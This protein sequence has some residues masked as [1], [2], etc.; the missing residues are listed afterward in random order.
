MHLPPKNRRTAEE[1]RTFLNDA[2]KRFQI[3][4]DSEASIREQAKI[5][6]AYILGDQWAPRAKQIRDDD[7]RPCLTINRLPQFIHQVTNEQRQL[8][9]SLQVSP[10][11][12][13]ESLDT[14]TMRTYADIWQGLM[15]HIEVNSDAETAY[16][17]A[18]ESMVGISFGWF[19]VI[20]EYAG[21]DTFDQEISIKR[22]LD[23]FSVYVDP[24]AIEPDR[25]DMKWAFLTSSMSREQFKREYPNTEMVTLDFFSSFSGGLSQEWLTDQDVQIAEYY[26]V[27]YD[28]KTLQE[29]TAPA[30]LAEQL[31]AIFGEDK[32][33]KVDPPTDGTTA[34]GT[35]TFNAYSDD[36]ET[37]PKG[38]TVENER[39]VKVPMVKWYK[40]TGTDIL[41]ETDWAG[42]WI[43]LIPAIGHEAVKDGKK[44]IIS[45]TRFIRDSQTL[46]NYFRSQQAEVIALTPKAPFIGPT[47]SFKTHRLRWQ[48]ANNVNYSYL[49]FD[50]VQGPGG[51]LAP[52]P[53]RNAVEPPIQ[54]ITMAVRDAVDDLNAG[55][56]IYQAAL[57]QPSNETSGRAIAA[58]QRESDTSNFHFMDN[59]R[60]SMRHLGRLLMD[61]IPHIYD[62]KDRIVRIV[63]PDN[64]AELVMIN[65]QT[66]YKGKPIFFDPNVGRYDVTIEVGPSFQSKIEQTFE[67]LTE[68]AAAN[69]Q[70]LQVAGDLYMLAAPL[71]GD[72]GKQMADRMKAILPPQVAAT[73]ASGKPPDPAVQAQLAQSQQLIQALG[74]QVQKMG[75]TIKMKL[76]ETASKERIANTQAMV[77][78]L[79]ADLKAKAENA[80]VLTQEEYAAIKHR[81]DLLHEGIGL[82]MEA[83]GQSFDQQHAV[84][85]QGL[86]QQ[87]TESQQQIDQQPPPNGGGSQ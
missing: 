67:L 61:L 9:P 16:D 49:E 81:L 4:S 83:Q 82:E 43:P 57:G 53:I 14:D 73:I 29:I 15:R 78:L 69:P 51:M 24:D 39:E 20:T 86:D 56:G 35:V 1:T 34:E 40:I 68:L 42:R 58:R 70:F 37:L 6:N 62:R 87:N 59:F 33:G 26:V 18:F 10:L 19:R 64:T 50:P 36:Y 45:L 13:P 22:I 79:A 12:G 54:A 11:G 41:D 80:Q 74:Q 46:L 2:R 23:P 84:R 25:S 17:T 5:D 60:R 31:V 38:A 32:V 3:A 30:A 44:Q 76:I 66:Q 7:N 52:A 71:P 85:Q 48:T 47:G 8:R 65:G 75:E 77:T 72:L 21:D 27:D 63:K 28:K 55:S